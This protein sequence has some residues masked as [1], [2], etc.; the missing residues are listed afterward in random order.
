MVKATVFDINKK[1]EDQV[2]A[3]MAMTPNERLLLCLDLMDLAVALRNGE[4]LPPK[5]D[6]IEWIELKFKD[7]KSNKGSASIITAEKSPR[8]AA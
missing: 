4:A 5:E 6:N 7:A 1:K 2:R 3:E 8:S